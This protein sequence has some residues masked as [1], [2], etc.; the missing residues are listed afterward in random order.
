MLVMTDKRHDDIAERL[1]AIRTAFSD[2]NRREWSEAQGFNV[3]QYVNWENGTRRI[4]IE[5]AER[6]CDRYGVSLDFIY[7]GRLEGCSASAIKALS[8]ILRT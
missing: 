7:R 8:G 1:G 4:P 3:T 6:L 2:M 5:A